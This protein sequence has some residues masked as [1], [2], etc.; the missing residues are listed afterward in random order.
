MYKGKDRKTINI[1]SELFPFGG[2]L[3]PENRWLKIADLIPWE[4]LESRYQSYFS[5]R[6]RPAKDGRLVIGILLLKHMTGLSDDEIV[7][8]VSENPYM[9]GFCGI[10]HFVTAPLLDSSSLSKIRKRLGKKYFDELERETYRV[11]IEQKIIKGKGMLIDATVFPEYIRY[12]TDPG[13]LNEARE[14]LVKKIKYLGSSLGIKVRT[15]CRKAHKEYLNFSKKKNRS[16]KVI[17][18][19][20]KSLLQHL[21]RN[22]NQM[23]SLLSKARYQGI[24]IEQKV[25][26]RFDVVRT[27]YKQ[28]LHMYRHN[29]NRISER[30]VSLYRPWTRPIVRGKSGNKAVEFGPKAA[31]SNVDGFVFLGHLS[32][33][34]FSEAQQTKNQVEQFERFFGKPPEYV[35]GDK[36]YGNKDNRKYVK[37]HSIRDAFEPLGRKNHTSDSSKRWRKQKQRER[38]RIEGSIGHGKNH[39]GLDKIKYY[40]KDGPEIWIRLGLISMNLKTAANKI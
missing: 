14:W 38:N 17:K 7:K 29:I 20:K 2:K 34:N 28:Q 40:I 4:H 24:N 21:R 11:L 36:H 1:F 22:I 16:L 15:Y 39:F 30:I 19:I 27:V 5:D 9:Q 25:L 33:E 13:L 31:L 32:S 18:R 23:E 10:G 8:Q 12:P 26:E 35:V 3:D 37:E 6:G